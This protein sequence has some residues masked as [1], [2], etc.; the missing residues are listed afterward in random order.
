[1]LRA[2]ASTSTRWWGS[3]FVV[4]CRCPGHLLYAQASLWGRVDKALG[5]G[6]ALPAATSRGLS[7]NVAAQLGV[8]TVRLRAGAFL[9]RVHRI[10][11][12]FFLV[13]IPPAGYASFTG[14]PNSPS[15]VVYLPLFPL[16][17]LALTGVYQLVEPW[18]SRNR[19]VSSEH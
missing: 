3:S 10:S 5:S 7:A 15:P 13:S 18:I 2:E 6:F 8:D 1:M 16:L 12:I 9:R 11:A 17:G 4:A 19:G 14:D